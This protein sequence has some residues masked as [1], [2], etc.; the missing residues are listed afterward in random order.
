MSIRNRPRISAMIIFIPFLVSAVTGTAIAQQGDDGLPDFN[1]MD[2]VILDVDLAVRI[3]QDRSYRMEL[4]RFGL[5]RSRYNL[6]ASRAALKSNASMNFIIPDFDQSIKEIIDPYTG[7]PRVLS[8]K[9]ARYSTSITV[10]QPLPT[11]GMLSLSGVM[12][13]TSDELFSYTP[14]QKSYY[15]RLLLRF[16]QPILQPNEIKNDIRKAELDLEATELGF[17]DEEIRIA[18]QVSRSFY[19]LFELTHEDM[20]A[21]GEAERLSEIYRIGQ[22]LY[23]NEVISEVNLLQ[24]EVNRATSR[25]E[26]SA[27][28]GR[29]AREIDDFKQEV[30]LPVDTEIE[31]DASMEYT[32]EVIDLDAMI[33]QALDQRSDLRSTL[34]RREQHE[35]DLRERRS[36]GRLTGDVSLTLGLEGRGHQMQELYD[37]ISDPDQARGASIKF[38]LPLWDWGRNRARVNSKQTELDQNVRTEEEQIR[39]IRR[40]VENAVARVRE[41]ESRLLL[42]EPSVGASVRSYG[43]ALEQFESGSL[44][45]QDILLT[46]DQM[47]DARSSYLGAFLD[48]K[49]ALV[50]LR[51]V[52]TGSGYGG[53][54]RG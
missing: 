2:V 47:S 18:T 21:A 54:F 43:L 25:N 34:R 41:A 17:R 39:S 19:D 9:G 10:R 27:N 22:Q 44:S 29:L 52:T 16:E 23:E 31:I 20:I 11:D 12:N 13:R 24:L 3:A 35:M 37:A 33:G 4:G 38:E 30:G 40:E 45:V 14:G 32:S 15:S 5:M 46:Q 51:A 1:T 50:D 8:T 49:R 6:E 53:R 28:A 42:L 26:A 7:N 36:D 48:F